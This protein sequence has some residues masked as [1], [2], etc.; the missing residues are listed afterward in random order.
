MDTKKL[1]KLIQLLKKHELSEIEVEGDDERIR[2]VNMPTGGAQYMS[3]APAPQ[4]HAMHTTTGA[5]EKSSGDDSSVPD[6][7]KIRSPF[8]GT[9]YECPSPG[10]D[11]FVKV[12]QKVRKG[13]TLCIIEAMKIMNEIECEQDGTIKQI[14]VPNESSVE[15]NQVLFIVE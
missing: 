8:V 7:K 13:D 6:S 11:S 9:Y 2:L 10:A 5:V 14:L 1:E 4:P 15:F 3:Y 12:G